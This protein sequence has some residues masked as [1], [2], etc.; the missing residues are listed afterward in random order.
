MNITDKFSRKLRDLR[1]SVTDKCNFRCNYCMPSEI[2]DNNYKFISKS[3]ILSF[4]EIIRLVNIFAELGTKK[5][6]LTG[7]E[8]ILRNNLHL[9]I[10]RLSEINQSVVFF[11][12]PKK[13]NRMIPELKNYF[14]GRKIIFC[15]EISKLYE[16]YIRKNIDDLEPFE[17]VPKGELTIVISE[18]IDDKN[19]SQDLSESDKSLINKM[20]KKLSIKEI[21]D[22][23]CQNKKISKKTIYNYCLKLKNEN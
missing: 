3:E 13:I 4:E 5:I 23:I 18:K 15:R 7:G 10:K 16:E 6:R 1:I 19:T 20:I 12:S 17:K 8:P 22:I 14:S 2:F 11:V 21:T 9:L